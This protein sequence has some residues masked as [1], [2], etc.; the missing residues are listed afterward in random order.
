MRGKPE[1]DVHGRIL[2]RIIPAHAGQTGVGGVGVASTT[3]HPRACGANVLPS[4][5][6]TGLFGS[7]P[8]MRGK[9]DTVRTM[10]GDTRII[11]A[12]AGRTNHSIQ[13]FWL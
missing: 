11:P 8:R 1:D 10:V 5:T 7:S 12:H 9:R 2:L 3:D 6:F 4:E 13:L